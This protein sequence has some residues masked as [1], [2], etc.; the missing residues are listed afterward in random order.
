[1]SDSTPRH[2]RPTAPLLLAL[3]SL[4]FFA[5]CAAGGLP[6]KGW[7]RYQVGEVEFYSG[8]RPARVEKLIEG[9]S[10]FRTVLGNL[11]SA[12]SVEPNLPTRVFL[13]PDH[14]SYQRYTDH[15]RSGGVFTT[16]NGKFTIALDA[17][18]ESGVPEVLLH[19]YTHLVVANT[20]GAR[21]PAWYQEGYA[22]L[23]STVRIVGQDVQV[24]RVPRH[25]VSAAAEFSRWIPLEELLAGDV[26]RTRGD[27]TRLHR[28]YAQAW[29]AVHYLSIGAPEIELD[30]YL[31]LTSE[32]A[33]P[34]KTLRDTV[35]LTPHEL[36]GQL[37]DYIRSQNL[38]Y[39]LIPVTEFDFEDGDLSGTELT[40]AATAAR[41]ADMC[42]SVGNEGLA[43]T[44]AQSAMAAGEPNP[45]P[46]N[47]G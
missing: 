45:L 34:V 1:M 12:E 10:V 24:G 22:E 30:E 40:P 23:M 2:P 29:T 32:G 14:S 9:F 31:R 19:E 25:A 43:V 18:Q 42:W 6:R 36:E 8:A 39:Q 38:T 37:R 21:Y 35:G 47:A 27:P 15:K 28:A 16:R 3:C 17:Q 4:L 26:F 11:I 46:A 20:G 33:D 44:L 5:G 41:L 7:T 13:F